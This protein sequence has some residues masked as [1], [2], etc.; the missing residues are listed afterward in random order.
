MIEAVIFDL[1][2]LLVDSEPHWNEARRQM[3]MEHGKEWTP[4]DQKACMGVS[5]RAWADYMI[6][7]LELDLSP[8]QVISRIVGTLRALYARQVP[9]LPGAIEAVDLAARYYPTALASGSYRS[10]I[11]A[12]TNDTPMRGKFKVVVCSDEVPAGKPAPDVYLKA[13]HQL[14]VQTENCVCLEDSANGIRAGKAAGMKVIAVPDHQSPPPPEI[15]R[16]ADVVLSTLRDFGL[17]VIHS[18]EAI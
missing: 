7:R 13:A 8:D 16:Q 12:I 10:L 15:L 5:T 9:Y 6:R 18:L 4:D 11:D 3:A 2:G 14:G 1:D 17:Q